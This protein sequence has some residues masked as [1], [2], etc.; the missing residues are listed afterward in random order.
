MARIVKKPEER[1]RELI[2]AALELF[3]SQGYGNTTVEAVIRKT[4]I[5]KG[6]FYHYFQSKEDILAAVVDSMLSRVIADARAVSDDLSLNALEKLQRLLGGEN[7]VFREA[8][9]MAESLH[10]PEN[11][12]LH[13]KT[14]VEIVL[15]L[16]PVLADV[17]E[18][19]VREGFFQ[20]ENVLETVQF[21]LAGSQF[22]F[23]LGL[24]RWS[25]EEALLR[26]QAM[27][28]VIERTLGAEKGTFQ[29]LVNKYRTKEL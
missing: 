3:Q 12:E 14:N 17:I 24:F 1:R 20:V 2:E 16:S 13:E 11:R 28:T 4:G 23:D 10:H 21:L 22:L 8:E 6:T 25:R 5:A 26:A 7:Q 15:Q 29:F 9:G 18:Q 19:G 27:A